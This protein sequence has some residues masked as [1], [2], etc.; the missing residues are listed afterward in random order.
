MPKYVYKCPACGYDYSEYRL[1]TQPPIF[2]QC[3]GCNSAEFV[4]VSQ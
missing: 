2:T 1:A 3:Q 4:E